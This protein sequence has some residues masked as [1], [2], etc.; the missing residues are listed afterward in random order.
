MFVH[1]IDPILLELGPFQIRYYGIIFAIGVLFTYF[2]FRK[3]AKERKIGLTEDQLSEGAIILLLSIIIGAR[4]GSVIS[5]FSYYLQNPLQ[6]FAIWQ[7]GLAFHGALIGAILA[8]LY[9]TKKHKL[10]FYE[11]A[12]I[13]VIPVVLAL[14]IGRIANF[15][16]GEFYGTLT[17]LPWGVKF[18]GVEGFRH[19]VQLYES[20]T[21]FLTFGILW[22]IKDKKLPKGFIFWSF[23]VIYSGT[24]FL[25]EFL[26]DLPPLAL[27]LTWGQVWSLPML[28]LGVYMLAKMTNLGRVA[29]KLD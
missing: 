19:P 17:G 14:G 28:L 12:D 21:N 11:L 3:L 2:I 25:L 29:P 16:N 5:E 23:F 4:I 8:G 13:M 7:G 6:I 20:L 15:L 18:P 27:G 26:K 10:D 1:S 24:R 9:F 22:T